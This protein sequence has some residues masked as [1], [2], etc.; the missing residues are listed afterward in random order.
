[1]FIKNV[2][3]RIFEKCQISYFPKKWQI[4]KLEIINITIFQVFTSLAVFN[5]LT[6]PLNAFPWVIN[7][8]MEARVSL[9]RLETFLKLDDVDWENYYT[10]GR[11]TIEDGFMYYSTSLNTKKSSGN[12]RK[13]LKI[14]ISLKKCEVFWRFLKICDSFRLKLYENI[15]YEDYWISNKE[16]V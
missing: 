5:I 2:K 13:T 1:M 6:M 7:G 11:C 16:N 3:F 8:F 4:W 15:H 10:R 9:R 12:Q 14:A